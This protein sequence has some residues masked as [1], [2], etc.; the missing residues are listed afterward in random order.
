MKDSVARYR[1]IVDNSPDSILLL[2]MNGVITYVNDVSSK[3][4]GYS[5]EEQ[6]GKHI[7]KVGFFYPGDIPKYLNLVRQ[8]LSGKEYSALEMRYKHKN[9]EERIAQVSASAVRLGGKVQGLQAVWR[10]VTEEHEKDH[11]ISELNDILKILNKIM[12]HDLQN[13]LSVVQGNI[14]NYL[15]YHKP[16]NVE[17]LLKEIGEASER[18]RSLIDQMRDLEMAVSTGEELEPLDTCEE[19]KKVAKAFEELDV[20]ITGCVKILADKAFSSVVANIFR[21]AIKHGGAKHVR[22][23]FGTDGNLVVVK[24][25]DDGKG[26]PDE[27]KDK[28]FQEG[29]K[30]GET[31]NTGLGLYIIRKTIE[32]YGGSVSVEDNEPSGAVFVLK[33]PKDE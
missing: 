28:L 12:R 4:G 11:K 17:E 10:D 3:T 5:K 6:I 29:A 2:D 21:N 8:V 19:I 23:L 27:I 7:S 1:E 22:V 24:F 18:G 16:E 15:E 20:E 14:D 32:R 9:G 33:I 30:F 26:I 31:G 25:A 13:D